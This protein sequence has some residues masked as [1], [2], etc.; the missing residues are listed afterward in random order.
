MLGTQKAHAQLFYEFDLEA[1]IP[2]N[3]LVRCIDRFLVLEGVREELRRFYSHTGRPSIDPELIILSG[4]QISFEHLQQRSVM[5]RVRRAVVQVDAPLP[6]IRVNHWG[7]LM[8]ARGAAAYGIEQVSE[9]T[10]Q[11]LVR[12]AV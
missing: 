7:D 2:G 6:E 8:W 11:E 12:H 5:E 10:V 1:H 3:H 4:A 9:L